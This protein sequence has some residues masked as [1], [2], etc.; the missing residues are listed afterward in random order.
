V[1]EL[2]KYEV[3]NGDIKGVMGRSDFFRFCGGLTNEDA[4]TWDLEDLDAKLNQHCPT[5]AAHE[6]HQKNQWIAA[7]KRIDRIVE[8]KRPNIKNAILSQ[9]FML[10]F[11]AAIVSGVLV[12]L[13][14]KLFA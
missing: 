9:K 8:N 2:K 10:G 11:I 1:P 14:S 7:R 13:I 6:S 5:G 4:E 3:E 12:N